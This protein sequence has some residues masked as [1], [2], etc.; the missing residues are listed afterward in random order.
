M[1]QVGIIG[2]PNAGKSTL[3]NAL[4]QKQQALT[5]AYPFTTVAPNIGIVPVPDERLRKIAEVVLLPMIPAIVRFVD[6]AGLVEG[7]HK[8]AGLGNAFLSYIKEVDIICHV[9]RV[10]ADQ[11]VPREKSVDPA[12]DYHT[13]TQELVLA[14]LQ[15][16]E[17]VS[18][19]FTKKKGLEKEVFEKLSSWLRA[20]RP[21]RDISLRYEELA[22]AKQF[23]LLTL[24]QELVVLNVSEEDYAAHR[25][26]DIAKVHSHFLAISPE[27]IV[28]ICAKIEADM[29]DFSEEERK[30]YLQGLGL[31]DSGVSLLIKKAYEALGLISFYTTTGGKEVRAWSIGRGTRA[32]DAAAMI[33]TDFAKR[34]IKAEIIPQHDF[35][36]LGGWKKARE[37]GRTRFEGRDYV[38]LDGDVVEFRVGT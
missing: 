36:T 17:N 22:I 37:Q 18:S 34:F 12:R 10:F 16:I 24:K 31:T 30:K 28:V 19:R 27:G 21:V 6:I 4:L 14:D 1:L 7:A 15:T 25:L 35:V 8:G 33:H 2:L 38:V 23:F 9:L 29:A 11:N 3:F 13:V 5:A 20:G 26:F 32:V